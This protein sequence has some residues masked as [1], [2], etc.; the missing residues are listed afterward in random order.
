MLR[1][2]VCPVLALGAAACV[3]CGQSTF[4]AEDVKAAAEVPLTIMPYQVA[5]FVGDP[6]AAELSGFA[7]FSARLLYGSDTPRE[8]VILGGQV[9][10]ATLAPFVDEWRRGSAARPGAASA[11]VRAR[12]AD[13]YR[14]LSSPRLLRITLNPDCSIDVPQRL[15]G[16]PGIAIDVPCLVDNRR[17]GSAV[18]A[19]KMLGA[20]A[21]LGDVTLSPGEV[22]GIFLRLPASDDV[23]AFTVTVIAGSESREVRLPVRAHAAGRLRVRVLDPDGE[24]TPARVYLWGADGRAHAPTGT[25]HRIVA[26]G[27]G[28]PGGGEPYFFTTGTFD[29]SMPAGPVQLEVVKGF[30]YLPVRLDVRV[31]PSAPTDCTVRLRRREWVKREGWHSGDSHVHANLFAQTLITPDDALRIAQAEDLN[32]MNLLPCNDPRTNVINDRQHFTGGPH[33]V[34]K[35]GTILYFSEEMRNDLYGHVGFLGLREFVEPAYFGWPNS[36]FP[37][38]VP[39]NHPQCLAARAQGAVVTYV[40]PSLPSAFPADIALGAAD[41]IDVMSQHPEEPATGWWYRLLN[42]GFRCPASAGPDSFLNIPMHLL[43]GACRVYVQLEGRLTFDAWLDAFKRGRSYV[44]NGPLLRFDVDG[45]APGDALESPGPWTVRVRGSAESNV[46][47]ESVDLIVNGETVRRIS[48]PPGGLSVAF[49]ES[50][51][52]SRSGWVGV[53]VRGPAHRLVTADREVYAHTSPVYVTIG[54]RPTASRVAADFFIAQIEAMIA[55]VEF[56][57]S[58]A[59]PSDRDEIVRYF[60]RA[61]DVYRRIASADSSARNPSAE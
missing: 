27:Y 17:A 45:A 18:V 57:G 26:G 37:H 40:H 41:M 50:V 59:R 25:L 56:H 19:V 24:P 61:Q 55:K 10:K 42:C 32:V 31:D 6:A 5:T 4:A 60:R 30:E 53:R 54:G 23:S 21:P 14:Q 16:L 1:R 13:A 28:Q 33:A 3:W 35:P 22:R 20:S 36:P 34:S 12:I 7:E 39:G 47:M 8:P 58:F 51:T 44:T 2:I 9:V 29:L 43:P 11:L 38:D 49:D 48:V 46:P 52:L 15:D